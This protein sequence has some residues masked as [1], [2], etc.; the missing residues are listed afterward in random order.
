MKAL[1]K[2]RNLIGHGVWMWTNEERPLVVWHSKFLEEDDWVG[3]EFFDWA[4]FDY[5]MKR[6][7][8]LM[9]TFAQFKLLVVNIRPLMSR[10]QLVRPKAVQP[11]GYL[12]LLQSIPKRKH[13]RIDTKDLELGVV[14]HLQHL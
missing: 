9:N 13:R 8:V 3:A 6:A 10:R 1:G 7:T 11:R 5:F 12:R 4:R 2:E 14:N